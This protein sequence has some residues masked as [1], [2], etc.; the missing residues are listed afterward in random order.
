V[1]CALALFVVTLPLFAGETGSI[2]GKVTDASGGPLPGVI[3]KVAGAQLPAGRTAPTSPSGAYNF[4]RLLPGKYS[5]GADAAGIGTA[6]RTVDVK[7]D[8][9]S[10]VDLALRGGT[11]TSVDVSAAAVDTKSAEVDFNHSAEE[12]RNLPLTRT[13]TGLLQLV[14]GA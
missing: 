8:N 4:Q 9:D 11:E 13:Y 6:S 5:A 3:V 1:S 10:Q 12:I 7:V 2:S 14:P